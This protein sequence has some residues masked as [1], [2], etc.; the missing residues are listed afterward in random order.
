MSLFSNWLVGA[1]KEEGWRQADVARKLEVNPSVVSK[2]K[3]NKSKPNRRMTTKLCLLFN[4]SADYLVPLIDS[5]DVIGQT[6]PKERNEKRAELL[7]RLPSLALL[8]DAIMALPVEKQATYIDLMLSLLP[9]LGQ[10]A[11]EVK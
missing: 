5:R 1:M 2:W 9:G 7:A 11:R 10:I 8:L 6:G 4:V 3:N